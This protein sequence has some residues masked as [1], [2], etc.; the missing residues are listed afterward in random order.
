MHGNNL[1][2][3]INEQNRKYNV[4]GIL[5]YILTRKD[6]RIRFSRYAITFYANQA[7]KLNYS[8]ISIGKGAIIFSNYLVASGRL[9]R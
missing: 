7:R 4:R 1:V 2:D 9:V 8:S 5:K 3:I 6:T